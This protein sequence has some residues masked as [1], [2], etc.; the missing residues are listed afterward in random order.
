MYQID[1]NKPIHVYFCGI[2][3]ISM[4]GLAEI[5]KSRDFA[6][7][8]S[9][10]KESEITEGLRDK[11]MTVYIGQRASNVGDNIDLFVY[12]AAIHEDNPE[13]IAATD[14]NIP[15]LSRAELLGE[16]MRNFNLPIA[17]SGTH[18]K[19][20]TTSMI[21]E[22]LLTAD[23][24]PQHVAGE[25][26]AKGENIC[27]GYFKNEEATKAAFTEDGFL[28]TGDLGVIDAHGN[29]F[30]RGRSKSMILS[31][32]GQN[33][34]PEEVEAAVNSQDFVAESVVVDRGAKLVALVYLDHDAIRKA[35]LDEETISDIPER[36]RVNANRTLPSYSQIQ[37]VELVDK[38]FEK[39]PKMSIKRFM[40]K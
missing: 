32:N 8:G 38:P 21:S 14:K 37:K 3:G 5:L 22:A 35:G 24:D 10:M 16:I 4:S 2:G 33:I 26:Q 7:S 28:K 15:K 39:T 34:Y 29:I 18:G 31:A 6:I 40:Y 20:T 11:G 23:L 27:I 1:F 36:V 17:I 30:I 12:T 19:T 9:D 13:W 25:I